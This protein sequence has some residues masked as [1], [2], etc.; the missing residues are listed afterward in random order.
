MSFWW[1]RFAALAIAGVL[2]GLLGDPHVRWH[3]VCLIGAWIKK[4]ETVTRAWFPATVRAERLAGAFLVLVVTVVSGIV[5][6]FLLA[7]LY[8]SEHIPAAAGVLT[9]GVL[10]YFTFAARSLGQESLAV[11]DAFDAGGLEDA[12]HAVSMIVGRDTAALDEAGVIRAAVETVAENTSDGVI[13]PL[14][15]ALLGGAPLAYMY[16]AVNTMDS[17]VGYRNERYRHYGTAAARLD[18]LVNLIPARLSAY[19]MMGASVMLRHSR[20]MRGAAAVRLR[21]VYHIYRRDRRAHESP[22]SAQTESVMAGVLRV[23]LAGD[24]SYFGKVKKKPTIGDDRRAVEWEDIPRAVR[25]M[26]V[27]ACLGWVLALLICVTAAA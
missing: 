13:A 9:E 6:L 1:Y 11:A 14:F 3:P 5:P 2:D 23:R 10:L 26:Q 27:T 18:D 20:L 12:R 19:L 22:N 16:K 15:Y 21:E 24:A 8:T 4:V 17:M 7:F 25:L